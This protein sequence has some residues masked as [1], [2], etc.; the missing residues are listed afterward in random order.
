MFVCCE[1]DLGFELPRGSCSERPDVAVVSQFEGHLSSRSVHH[2]GHGTDDCPWV[3]VVQ[4]GKTIDL[5]VIDFSLT[6]RY[7]DFMTS[8]DHDDVIQSPVTD[9]EDYCHVYATVRELSSQGYAEGHIQVQGQVQG[10]VDS[11]GYDEVKICAGSRREQRVYTSESNAVSVRLSSVVF[12][13]PTVNFLLKYVGN[14]VNFSSLSHFVS[15]QTYRL[16]KRKKRTFT[17]YCVVFLLLF[18]V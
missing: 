18:V 14:F 12:D 1:T 11:Q 4:P 9:D 13:D 5:Y 2:S 15:L 17:N 6:S 16:I 3:I 8:A 7:Q 10:R